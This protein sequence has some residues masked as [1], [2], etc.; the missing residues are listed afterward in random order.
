MLGISVGLTEDFWG[1]KVT[2]SYIVVLTTR[3]SREFE[4]N[5]W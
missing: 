5:G 3:D 2:F 1:R 4:M